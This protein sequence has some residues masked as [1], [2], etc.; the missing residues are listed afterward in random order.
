[1]SFSREFT[2]K[3][4][5]DDIGRQKVERGKTWLVAILNGKEKMRQETEDRRPVSKPLKI[6]LLS[7]F[8]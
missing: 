4:F 5:Q 2:R 7:P 8:S 3:P 1:M 6:T